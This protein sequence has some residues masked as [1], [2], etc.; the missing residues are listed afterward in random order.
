MSEF[1]DQQKLL[2]SQLAL[3]RQIY[4]L[5]VHFYLLIN[6]K[7]RMGFGD[8]QRERLFPVYLVISVSICSSQFKLQNL[9]KRQFYQIALLFS[10]FFNYKT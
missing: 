4:Q 7:K 3:L 1:F 5:F 6:L 8:F 9:L 10:L 2:W